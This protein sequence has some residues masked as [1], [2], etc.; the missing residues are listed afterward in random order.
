[1]IKEFFLLIRM[2]FASNPSDF[3]KIKVLD[4]RHFPF[5]GYKAM[6]WCG[7]IIHR[8]GTSEVDD[9]TINHEMIH[10][11]QAKIC[12]SW[13]KYYFLY[14]IEWIKGGI[15]I[16]PASSAY[17]TSRYESEAYAN[18]DNP[19]YYLN[20]DGSNLQKYVFKNRKKLY[21]TIGGT[22]KKWISYVK[23]L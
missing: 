3:N 1:M 23:S 17:Y 22:S 10:L 18:E 21:R 5:R 13:I 16:N 11:S 7:V 2:M 12:G 8:I 4:M 6:A 9:K 20:Y 19:E 14:F 15:I